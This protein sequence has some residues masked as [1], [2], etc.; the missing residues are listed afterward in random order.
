MTAYGKYEVQKSR[1]LEL[2]IFL[3]KTRLNSVFQ[4]LIDPILI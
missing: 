4:F 2:C 3:V 1:M